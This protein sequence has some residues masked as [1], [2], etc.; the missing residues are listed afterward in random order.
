MV[1]KTQLQRIA[2]RGRSTQNHRIRLAIPI[3]DNRHSD[4]HNGRHHSTNHHSEE[5]K[6]TCLIVRSRQSCAPAHTLNVVFPPP[7][8]PHDEEVRGCRNV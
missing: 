7:W 3:S 1:I 4:P 8:N 5:E 6:E 2:A